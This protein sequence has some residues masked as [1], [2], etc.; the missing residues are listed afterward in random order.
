MWNKLGNAFKANKQTSKYCAMFLRRLSYVCPSKHGT[1]LKKAS[2]ITLKD[3]GR[4]KLNN[5]FGD[6]LNDPGRSG[7]N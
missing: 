4:H 3:S 5:N 2:W 7:R 1:D 6:V